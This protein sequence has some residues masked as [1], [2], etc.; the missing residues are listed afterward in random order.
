[1]IYAGRLSSSEANTISLVGYVDDRDDAMNCRGSS[2]NSIVGAAAMEVAIDLDLL[3]AYS[4]AA[5]LGK[6]IYRALQWSDE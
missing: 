6:N 2:L 5:D 3:T 4:V 1:L